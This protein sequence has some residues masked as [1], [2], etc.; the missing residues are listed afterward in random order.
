MATG[1]PIRA[2]CLPALATALVVTLLFS[3][4]VAH[5]ASD[6]DEDSTSEYSLARQ[7]LEDGDYDVAIENGIQ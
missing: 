1:S 3:P 2:I 6:E 4:S 5:A 7:A